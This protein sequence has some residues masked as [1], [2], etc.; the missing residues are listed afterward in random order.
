MAVVA[1]IIPITFSDMFITNFGMSF[2]IEPVFNQ[3][4]F[5]WEVTNIDINSWDKFDVTLTDAI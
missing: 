4:D 1:L 3:S 5:Y 2:D